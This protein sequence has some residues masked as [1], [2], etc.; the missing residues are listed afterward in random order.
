M[1]E[2]VLF[3]NWTPFLHFNIKAVSPSYQRSSVDQYKKS[4]TFVYLLTV[5]FH[6]ITQAS[7]DRHCNRLQPRSQP[8]VRASAC[9][10][11]A[12]NILKI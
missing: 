4:C 3:F 1:E 8:A 9:C 2:E 6:F 11:R 5:F 7:S 12:K 10:L